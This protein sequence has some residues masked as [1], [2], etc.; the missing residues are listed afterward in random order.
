MLVKA[1]CNCCNKTNKQ[2]NS[3]NTNVTCWRE[4][5][6][7]FT[8]RFRNIMTKVYR[9]TKMWIWRLCLCM[10]TFNLI[11][12]NRQR[13]C[14][15]SRVK[16]CPSIALRLSLTMILKFRI[17]WF[18]NCAEDA[19]SSDKNMTKQ[20]FYM[21]FIIFIKLAFFDLAKLLHIK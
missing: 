11:I 3:Q 2:V 20:N 13:Y 18:W 6:Y 12:I 10:I 8:L 21:T 1:T 5:R 9:C 17:G 7:K 14:I 19:G 16:G 4:K 15:T